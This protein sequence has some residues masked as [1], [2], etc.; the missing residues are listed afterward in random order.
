MSKTTGLTKRDK[1]VAE[2]R[3]LLDSGSLSIKS[4][5]LFIGAAIY[6]IDLLNMYSDFGCTDIAELSEK[7][8]YSESTGRRFLRLGKAIS[9]STKREDRSFDG[10]LTKKHINRLIKNGTSKNELLGRTPLLLAEKNDADYETEVAVFTET[11]AGVIKDQAE[12]EAGRSSKKSG[13]HQTRGYKS[14]LPVLQ[15]TLKDGADRIRDINTNYGGLR[16]SDRAEIVYYAE[17]T[18]W[19]ARH[20]F[21]GKVSWPNVSYEEAIEMFETEGLNPEKRPDIHDAL[22]AAL[23]VTK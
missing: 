13:K 22:T 21:N 4:A 14:L 15:E 1:Q 6:N 10:V 9:E 12:L 23:E 8:G 3:G 18:S 17:L 16:D 11:A 2:I 19:H 20:K 5:Q 7:Q